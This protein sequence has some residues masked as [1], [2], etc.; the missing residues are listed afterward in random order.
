M[1]PE[2]GPFPAPRQLVAARQLGSPAVA[3]E[4]GLPD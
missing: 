3:E 1:G 2:S 4:A